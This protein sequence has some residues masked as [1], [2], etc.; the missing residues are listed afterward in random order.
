MGLQKDL[1]NF[2]NFIWHGKSI[3]SYITFFIF[4]IVILNIVYPAFLFLL[5]NTIGINDIV[6]V[7]SGSMI[8]DSTTERTHYTYLQ[9]ELGIPLREI[10]A[11]PYDNG[12][13]PG[14]LML[15]WKKNPEDIIVGDILVFKKDNYLIIHRVI[16]IKFENEQYYYTTKGDHNPGSIPSELRIP[17]ELVKGVA[18]NRIPFLGIPK[19]LLTN[20]IG[21][22]KNVL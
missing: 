5:S 10:N 21:A 14:D 13:N 3:Y 9:Q 2:W 12:L 8:H 16:Q 1:K 20:F 17:Y 19:M 22:V 15:V 11:F 7:V 6:A 4:S 18:R